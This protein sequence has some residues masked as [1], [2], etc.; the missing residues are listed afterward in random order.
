MPARYQLKF[1]RHHHVNSHELH[2][3][4]H[5]LLDEL[6]LVMDLNLLSFEFEPIGQVSVVS[7]VVILL[8]YDQF[9]QYE[10]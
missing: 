2:V 1:L 10:Q 6:T 4:L 5:L 8:E 7:R 9:L 3:L